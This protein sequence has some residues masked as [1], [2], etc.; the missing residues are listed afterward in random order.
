[1]QEHMSAH[2][3][4]HTYADT[5]THANEP[6]EVWVHTGKSSTWASLFINHLIILLQQKI[7]KYQ[8]LW[9]IS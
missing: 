2:T 5:D 3:H 4:A 7:V 1:M 6:A 9:I 8:Q